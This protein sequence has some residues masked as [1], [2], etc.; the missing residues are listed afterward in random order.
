M[1]Y[2]LMFSHL[3]VQKG[4]DSRNLANESVHLVLLYQVIIAYVDPSDP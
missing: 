2:G 4:Y 3:H 1:G